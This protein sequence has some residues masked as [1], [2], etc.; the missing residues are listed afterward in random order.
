M[1]PLTLCH[2]NPF[3][4]NMYMPNLKMFPWSVSK[5]LISFMK[6]DMKTL[7]PSKFHQ[8]EGF[9]GLPETILMVIKNTYV[10]YPLYLNTLDLALFYI[11]MHFIANSLCLMVYEMYENS[12]S[13]MTEMNTFSYEILCPNDRSSFQRPPMVAVNRLR[14]LMS[15]VPCV[16]NHTLLKCCLL[17]VAGVYDNNVLLCVLSINIQSERLSSMIHLAHIV[18]W[19]FMSCHWDAEEI[20]AYSLHTESSQI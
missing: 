7:W 15:S 17:F 20:N 9:T 3:S 2:R 1:W 8:S 16:G 6:T 18:R 10:Q 5:L 11:L 12:F 19:G 4:S 13:Y 14:W